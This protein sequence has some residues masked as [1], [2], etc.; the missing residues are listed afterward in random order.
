MFSRIFKDQLNKRKLKFYQAFRFQELSQYY[1]SMISENDKIVH[2]KFG[3][4][5]NKNTPELEK[6]LK[7]D[8]AIRQI[9]LLQARCEDST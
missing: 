5:V 7:R 6:Q 4:N 8:V 1:S 3:A 9:K 2:N